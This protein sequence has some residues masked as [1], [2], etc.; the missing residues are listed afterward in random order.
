MDQ[1]QECDRVRGPGTAGERRRFYAA[2]ALFLLWVTALSV[3]A[4]FS[5]RR[6]APEP[7][8]FQGR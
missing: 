1:S 2:M 4:V 6:P 8:A 3:T 5:G 7:A